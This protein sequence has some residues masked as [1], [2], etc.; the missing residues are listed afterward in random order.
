MA[1]FTAH[2]QG[3]RVLRRLQPYQFLADSQNVLVAGVGGALKETH[4]ARLILIQIPAQGKVQGNRN[5]TGHAGGIPGQHVAQREGGVTEIAAAG[6]SGQEGLGGGR[7]EG[8]GPFPVGQLGTHV[9]DGHPLP[10]LQPVAEKQ[11]VILMIKEMVAGLGPL[12]LLADVVLKEARPDGLIY[13]VDAAHLAPLQPHLVSAVFPEE[14]RLAS[15][16]GNPGLAREISLDGGV[17]GQGVHPAMGVP[18]PGL[19]L[20][21]VTALAGLRPDIVPGMDIAAAAGS[22]EVGA[23]LFRQVFPPQ[24]DLL[25]FV[26][27]A[28]QGADA[29]CRRLSGG[30]KLL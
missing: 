7:I 28:D 4:D 16:I 25:P 9:D 17:V 13:L 24:R 23:N 8:V 29:P 12:G 18:G 21:L 11:H 30:Q 2:T 20:H 15:E 27:L 14:D 19:V 3:G 5:V 22:P 6:V 10:F 26:R 1:G